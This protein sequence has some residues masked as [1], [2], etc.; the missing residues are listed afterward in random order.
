MFEQLRLIANCMMLTDIM[1]RYDDLQIKIGPFQTFRQTF[2]PK[3]IK[4][5]NPRWSHVGCIMLMLV[6]EVF[7]MSDLEQLNVAQKGLMCIC[8]LFHSF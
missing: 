1:L 8:S 3:I 6:Y 7:T 2:G 4:P 5:D